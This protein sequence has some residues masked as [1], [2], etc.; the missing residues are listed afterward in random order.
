MKIPDALL[1]EVE[2]TARIDPNNGGKAALDVKIGEGR[3]VVFCRNCKHYRK[4]IKFP[5]ICPKDAVGMVV[6]ACDKWN[7]ETCPDGFCHHGEEKQ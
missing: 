7:G 2:T 1:F 3:S 4:I 6:I 5:T